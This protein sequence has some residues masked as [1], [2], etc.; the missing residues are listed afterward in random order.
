M[1]ILVDSDLV[2]LS[3]CFMALF[4]VAVVSSLLLSGRPRFNFLTVYALGLAIAGLYLI[5]LGY[6]AYEKPSG[7]VAYAI[8]SAFAIPTLLAA[9]ATGLLCLLVRWRS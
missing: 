4:A 2:A 6:N 3:L 8:Y 7:D 9:I 1:P 5:M